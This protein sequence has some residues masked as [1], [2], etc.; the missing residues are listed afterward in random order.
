MNQ[1]TRY[2]ASKSGPGR[3]IGSP[4]PKCT[5]DCIHT[6]C[7]PFT[8]V[9]A[10]VLNQ[11]TGD[12]TEGWE[13]KYWDTSLDDRGLDRTGGYR[14]E[15]VNNKA[16]SGD[17]F[18]K[19]KPRPLGPGMKQHLKKLEEE[20][21]SNGEVIQLEDPEAAE[22]RAAREEALDEERNKTWWKKGR[23]VGNQNKE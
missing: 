13:V 7:E 6:D 20:R 21:R 9:E 1:E 8:W 5:I 19:P 16:R 15:W 18:T 22:L 2:G 4:T 17:N 14:E 3:R 10:K 11:V 12:S 23:S